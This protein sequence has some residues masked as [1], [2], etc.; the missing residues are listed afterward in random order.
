MTPLEF[1]LAAFAVSVG[2]GLFG[3]V[4]GLGGGIVVVPA[5]TLLLHIDI[6]YAIGA[7]IVSV[8]ATSSGAGAAYV[9]QRLANIRVSMLL[10]TATTSGAIVGAFL[11]GVMHARWLFVVFGLVL[12][13]SAFEMWRKP[14][15]SGSG[16]DHPDA[17]ARRLSLRGSHFDQARGQEVSYEAKRIKA[18]LLI[19]SFAG[20]ISG[21]LGVGGG[22]IKV[23]AMNLVMGLPLKVA[24]ATSNFMIG[25]TAAASAGVYF[26]RGDI[27]PFIAAPVALGVVAG[28]VIGTLILERMRSKVL[29]IMFTAVLVA[30]AAQMLWR[31]MA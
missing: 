1:I 22:V 20:M 24:S 31:G 5:L 13:Y 25:V 6:R 14:R 29:R 3:A 11:V 7:S 21:L 23:P 28:A 9:K 4:L 10:E 19:C 2:A 27:N 26:Y 8:I 17:L 30:V 18:G 16:P 12:G 15:R